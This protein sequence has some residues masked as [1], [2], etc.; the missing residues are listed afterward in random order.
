MKLNNKIKVLAI[1]ISL[2]SNCYAIE[3]EKNNDKM[4]KKGTCIMSEMDK[5]LSGYVLKNVKVVKCPTLR[6]N[7]LVKSD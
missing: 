5:T 7:S 1:L 2:I 3:N 4:L 6:R